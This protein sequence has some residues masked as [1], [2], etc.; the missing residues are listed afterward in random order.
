MTT[1][2]PEALALVQEIIGEGCGEAGACSNLPCWC[3]DRIN[4]FAK[5]GVEK[6]YLN[7]LQLADD[8]TNQRTLIRSLMK[9]AGVETFKRTTKC[10]VCMK[11]PRAEDGGML[12]QQC[13]DQIDRNQP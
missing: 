12:C 1:D 5:A 3:A 4:A 2:A 10:L 9:L 7:C 13:R 8:M 11:N 6:A